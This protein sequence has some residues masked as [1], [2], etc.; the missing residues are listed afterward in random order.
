ML[1]CLLTKLNP[2]DPTNQLNSLERFANIA[3]PPSMSGA[4]VLIKGRSLA[5]SLQNI[6]INSL[7]SMRLI[8]AMENEGR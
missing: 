8:K 4:D 5:F 7:V 6:N 1:H 2:T 3:F